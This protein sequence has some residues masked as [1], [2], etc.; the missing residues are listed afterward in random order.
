MYVLFVI[1]FF[2][3]FGSLSL[4]DGCS[5]VK[6]WPYVILDPPTASGNNTLLR[7]RLVRQACVHA[8]H[9]MSSPVH[10]HSVTTPPY[11]PSHAADTALSAQVLFEY[12]GDETTSWH[13]GTE[14]SLT[15][16]R[17]LVA[18]SRVHVLVTSSHALP[19]KPHPL[20]MHAHLR[21]CAFRVCAFS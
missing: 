4:A 18:A 1:L 5:D 3:N 9:A 10:A 12:P 13:A 21:A 15:S 16:S 17:A 6:S 8:R 14:T 11:S 19:G 7:R 20:V 2:S